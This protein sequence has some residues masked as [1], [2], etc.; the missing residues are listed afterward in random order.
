MKSY[1]YLICIICMCTIIYFLFARIP[2]VYALSQYG[3]SGEEVKQIQ[4]KLKSRKFNS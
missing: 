4:T 3:S 2:M 1:K